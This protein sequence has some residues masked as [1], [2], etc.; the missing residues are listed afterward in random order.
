MK[1][2]LGIRNSPL[3]LPGS[4]T[5]SLFLGL[6][7]DNLHEQRERIKHVVL[8]LEYSQ[9]PKSEATLQGLNCS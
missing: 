5:V 1:P 3:F 6:S 7:V 4:V 2:A 9:R 8:I